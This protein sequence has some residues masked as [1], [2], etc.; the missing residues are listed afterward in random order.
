MN[1]KKIYKVV[2]IITLS[3]FSIPLFQNFITADQANFDLNIFNLDANYKTAVKTIGARVKSK[4]FDSNGI[5]NANQRFLKCNLKDPFTNLNNPERNSPYCQYEID[6]QIKRNST[7]LPHEVEFPLFIESQRNVTDLAQYAI[8]ENDLNAALLALKSLEWSF[9]PEIIGGNFSTDSAFRLWPAERRISATP[10]LKLESEI[11]LAHPKSNYLYAAARSLNLLKKSSFYSSNLEF[12]SRV[13]SLATKVS[14]AAHFFTKAPATN[15]FMDQGKQMNQLLFVATAIR[16][17]G[18]IK[19]NSILLSKAEALLDKALL[20]ENRTTNSGEIVAKGYNGNEGD[21]QYGVLYE[22]GG[23]DSSYQGVS[24]ELL[25]YYYLTV[26]D[27]LRK[28]Q[29]KKIILAGT[30]KLVSKIVIEDDLVKGLEKGRVRSAIVY[31]LGGGKCEIKNS[32]TQEYGPRNITS[33]PY[34]KGTDIDI[35]P[36]RLRYIAQLFAGDPNIAENL[37]LYA[38]SADLMSAYGQGFDHFSED[39]VDCSAL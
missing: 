10:V 7:L 29:L 15:G 19:N 6:I 17:A 5:S 16:A 4:S 27:S 30:D 32:R 34:T 9:S 39:T 31:Q 35:T 28:A 25:S 36:M 33:S 14:K 23:F 18:F 8:A 22:S 20:L 37:S 24:L 26:T 21:N 11:E 13:N 12:S 1:I 3:F 2:L 38:L